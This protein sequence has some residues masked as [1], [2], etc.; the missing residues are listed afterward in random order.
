MFVL[1]IT[2]LNDREKKVCFPENFHVQTKNI[3]IFFQDNTRLTP[4]IEAWS[5]ATKKMGFRIDTK[6][7]SSPK[8]KGYDPTLTTGPKVSW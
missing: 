2:V 8:E 7:S 3:H 6:E 4:G 1:L 5:R